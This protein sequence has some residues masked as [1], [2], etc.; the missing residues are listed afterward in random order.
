[1]TVNYT[2]IGVVGAGAMGRGIAQI[3]AQAGSEVLLLD[4]FEGA[5][6]RGR[7]A[8][9]AQW[10]KLHEKGRIDEAARDAQIARVKIAESAQALAGCDLV[11]EAVVENLEVKRKLF[12]ELEAI[13]APDAT[14]ATNTSSL[15]VTAIAAGLKHPERFAGFHFFNP[16][17]LMKVVEV[18]AGFKTAPEV[19]TRLA[20]YAAQMG[21]SAVQAQDTPGFIV[22]HAGRGYGTEALRI[23]G[24]GVT[25]FVTVD[26]ILREQAGFRLGPF[27]LLDLTALDVS[28]PVME[29]I[30]RQYYDEPRY[31]PSV[32]TAQRLAAGALGRKTGEGFYRYEDG[33]MQQAPEAPAPKLDTL[34]AVWVSPRAARRAELLRLVNTLGAQIDS[35]AT[36]SPQSLIL[37]APLGFDVTTVAAVD[38]L[39]ATRT[40]GIDMLIDDAA[41][42]RRVLATNP[43][44]RRDMR[45]AA[46][47]L[48]ARD[49]KAVSVIRDS[50]GFVTQRVIGTIVNIA[51]DMC[52][53]RVCTP[54]DLET[55]VQLG[56]GYPRGPLAMGNLY[57]PTN[58]LEVLFNMQ[59]VYGDP[60]YRPS[61][62]LRRRG[63]LG[64]SLLHEEE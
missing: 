26:R 47:A 37:V 18:V 64:L 55:A 44:T 45:D 10:N 20:G 9:V 5:A 12:A 38:R 60:R 7:D 49:G 61:P 54:G 48:F 40:V 30:Y 51:A 59:T 46:H 25:D 17:P 36:A 43:A 13:V 28:H 4:S 57:G 62:W 19:C 6:A 23:V 42:K 16:V 8:I 3:A 52:Q 35:G 11:I 1:M 39:D 14:L 31:R 58:M 24:E 29:S 63:A 22:N 2:R 41:S 27:E 56:L 33:A 32:I 50:G 15:S 53:Q 34:P 21:H